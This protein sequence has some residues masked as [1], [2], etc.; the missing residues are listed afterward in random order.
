MIFYRDFK[1]YRIKLISS[2]IFFY[3]IIISKNICILHVWELIMFHQSMRIGAPISL[4]CLSICLSVRLLPTYMPMFQM[5]YWRF[6][7]LTCN[8]KH[9]TPSLNYSKYHVFFARLRQGFIFHSK[10]SV[11]IMLAEKSKLYLLISLNA[12]KLMLLPF[13]LKA[14]WSTASAA[15]ND[16]A[17][18]KRWF[19][20]FNFG[21]KY[22]I[23]GKLQ[24]QSKPQSA[25]HPLYS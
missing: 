4:L 22:Q 19:N 2:E 13:Q 21:L 18:V 6:I 8:L 25:I 9:Y 17:L 14:H 23:S 11:F 3:L 24:T 12:S 16:T 20:I 15:L 7:Y 5:I 1:M 10:I